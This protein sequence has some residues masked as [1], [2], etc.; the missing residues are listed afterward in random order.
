LVALS[1]VKRKRKK[2]ERQKGKKMTLID[3]ALRGGEGG[4]DCIRRERKKRK[5]RVR[6]GYNRDR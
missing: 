4:E 3:F 1:I 2:R 5:K 6:A